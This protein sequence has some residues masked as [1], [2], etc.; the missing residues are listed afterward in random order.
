MPVQRH[1]NNCLV[2]IGP[3]APDTAFDEAET[4]NAQVD[5]GRHL[6]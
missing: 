4:L 2:T 5:L 3:D 1:P 6:A